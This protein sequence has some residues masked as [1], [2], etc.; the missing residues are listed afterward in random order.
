MNSE[1]WSIHTLYS[2]L[3]HHVASPR[4]ATLLKTSKYPGIKNRYLC[5]LGD[6]EEGIV[7]PLQDRVYYKLMLSNI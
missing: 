4:A 5:M 7:V 1:F 2:C 3:E 6:S